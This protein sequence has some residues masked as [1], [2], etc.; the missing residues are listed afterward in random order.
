M[1]PSSAFNFPFVAIVA[2]F[3]SKTELFINPEKEH[4]S[5]NYFLLPLHDLIDP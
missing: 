1:L 4:L 3:L 2:I 5:T